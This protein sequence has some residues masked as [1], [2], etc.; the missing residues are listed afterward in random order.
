MG[1]FAFF[2]PKRTGFF[3]F[4]QKKKP[5]IA[6]KITFFTHFTGGICQ[7]YFLNNNP[8]KVDEV[9]FDEHSM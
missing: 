9:A 2:F 6:C 1:L 5:E 7:S 8:L 3:G 4:F